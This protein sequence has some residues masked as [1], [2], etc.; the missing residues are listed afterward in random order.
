MN[1]SK[2]AT[3]LSAI[4]MYLASAKKKD[5]LLDFNLEYAEKEL[6]NI[7]KEMPTAVRKEIDNNARRLGVPI[8][9]S[10]DTVSKTEYIAEDCS[11]EDLLHALAFLHTLCLS[12]MLARDT[13]E[14]QGVST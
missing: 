3:S 11:H 10:D 7:F 12:M 8:E 6:A 2:V 13:K 14:A 5:F 9:W 4:R 1:S